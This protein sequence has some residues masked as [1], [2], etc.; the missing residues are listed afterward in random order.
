MILSNSNPFE[1]PSFSR[2]NRLARVLWH[3][4]WLFLFRPTPPFMH[5]WRCWLL[6][7]FGASI[8]PG[9]HVYSA[10]RIWAPWNLSMASKACLGPRVNCY[11]I[12]PVALGERVVVSQ[13]V[14]LCTG[15]HNYNL[16]SFPLFAEPI[17]IESDAWICT[18]AFVGPGV[19]VGEGSVIG[20]RAVVIS[21]QPKWMVCVG[22]PA[23]PLKA[24]IHPKAVDSYSGD[25]HI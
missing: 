8:A 17:T 13:G 20:A 24:R 12:A 25:S 22:N 19:S 14:Y 5:A 23:R 10:A 2:F 7:F 16:I 3:L 9:C 18:E 1:G 15:S 21:S 4:V 11:C 6:R